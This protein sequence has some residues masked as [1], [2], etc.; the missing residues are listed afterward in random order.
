[1]PLFLF[2]PRQGGT[3]ISR[4]VAFS[5]CFKE[6]PKNKPALSGCETIFLVELTFDFDFPRNLSIMNKSVG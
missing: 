3:E 5:Y 1:M 6:L 4:N 2:S